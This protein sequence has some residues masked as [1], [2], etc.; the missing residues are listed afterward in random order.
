MSLEHWLGYYTALSYA[1]A[2][3]ATTPAASSPVGGL[4][5][6]DADL[7][8]LDAKVQGQALAV[9]A[10][11]GQCP[12]LASADAISW[13]TTFAAWQAEHTAVQAAL[14]S[15]IVG[16]GDATMA[17][18]LT[19]LQAQILAMQ[20]RVHA[21]CPSAIGGTGGTSA[22]WGSVVVIVGIAAALAVGVW[23]LAPVLL[24]AIGSHRQERAT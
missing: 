1:H 9:D 20:D 19:T 12:A 24:A 23:A 14:A 22:D 6:S 15:S 2:G 21:A 3:Q 13:A 18:N 16:L 8:A 11:V 10:A 4:Y 5:V 7:Q 17:A